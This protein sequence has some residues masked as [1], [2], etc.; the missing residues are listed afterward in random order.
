MRLFSKF[1]SFC[2]VASL[3]HAGSIQTLTYETSLEGKSSETNWTVEE[4]KQKIEVNGQ[5]KVGDVKIEYSPSFALEHYLE[6]KDNQTALDIF[7]EGCELLVKGKESLKKLKL[8]QL[9]WVQEFKFGFQPF[10]QNAEK[11]FSFCIVYA[12]DHSLHDMIATKEKIETLQIGSDSYEAQKL[13]ITLRGF[14]KKFWKAEAWFD[15][16]T[17]LLLK[18]KANEGPGTPIT[19][20]TL[21]KRS[22]DP[23]L[24]TQHV[25]LST[26]SEEK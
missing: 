20:V 23:S 1:L 9:P 13:K 7:K 3:A 25:F 21:I 19:E 11:E 14:K 6:V 12:K 16:K 2:C 4:T 17:H 18:Y 10:L 5:N 8:K 15:V 22:Q 26:S 24:G